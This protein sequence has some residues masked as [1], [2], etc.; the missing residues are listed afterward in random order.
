MGWE[1][2]FES[3]F[4]E[5]TRAKLDEMKLAYQGES[6]LAREGGRGGLGGEGGRGGDA[7][8]RDDALK[9]DAS[10]FVVVAPFDPKA[11]PPFEAK[12]CSFGDSM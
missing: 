2:Y 7:T 4:Q 12:L 11:S 3:I 6:L 10:F 1:A 5:V 8:R 9:L